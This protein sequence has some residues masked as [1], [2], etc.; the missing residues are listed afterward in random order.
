MFEFFQSLA[1]LLPALGFL[2]LN[3]LI[4]GPNV[5]N[6]V[7]TSIGS[8]RLSSI[9]CA[10]ACGVGLFV[11]ALMALLGAAALFI[12][13][14]VLKFGLTIFGATLLWYFATRYCSKAISK[15]ISP[16]NAITIAEGSAFRRALIIM[17]ANPKVLTTWL[18]VISLFPI[19]I[20]NT[21]NIVTFSLLSGLASFVGHAIYALIFS[22]GMARDMYQKIHRLI[23]GLVGIGFYLYGAQLIYGLLN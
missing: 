9:Y 10:V 8:S 11:W 23:N 13:F 5:L 17:I 2:M 3:V 20:Q 7:G 21:F 6:T 22:S 18:A 4:P 16:L 12:T 1:E 19:I 15:T 14:P